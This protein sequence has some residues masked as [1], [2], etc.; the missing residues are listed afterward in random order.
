MTLSGVLSLTAFD[1]PSTGQTVV[2]E[3]ALKIGIS[4]ADTTGALGVA[5]T[6]GNFVIQ[7]TKVLEAFD[8]PALGAAAC[9]R[10]V[11]LFGSC[12]ITSVTTI[13]SPEFE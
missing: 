4:L 10:L 12:I 7:T 5:T 13:P 6:S 2:N 1:N 11:Q 8:N 9:P 3:P